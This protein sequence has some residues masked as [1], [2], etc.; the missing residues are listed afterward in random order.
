M[1]K[2]TIIVRA[3]RFADRAMTTSDIT[4]VARTVAKFVCPDGR[5]QIVIKRFV[6]QIVIPFMVVVVGQGNASK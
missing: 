6:N 2:I 5:D 3:Q 4:F 1:I